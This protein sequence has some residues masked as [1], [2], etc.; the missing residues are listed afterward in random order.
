MI[1][2]GIDPGLT[3]GLAV[4]NEMDNIE[5]RM[6]PVMGA[7]KGTIVDGGALARWLGDR[8]VGIC[9]VERAGPMPSQGLGSTFKFGTVYGQVLGALQAALVPDTLVHTRPR[10]RHVHV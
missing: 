2:G 9:I 5:S 4:L 7:D 3:G 8:D 1:I 6:M 10:E